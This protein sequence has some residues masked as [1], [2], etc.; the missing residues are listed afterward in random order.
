MQVEDWE[1][2]Y[3]GQIEEINYAEAQQCKGC[4][5]DIIKKKATGGSS[6]GITNNKQ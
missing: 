1:P 6:L 2:I 5:C 4:E 3:L